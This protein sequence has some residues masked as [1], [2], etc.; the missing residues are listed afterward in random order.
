MF[1]ETSALFAYASESIGQLLAVQ[2]F[3]L[4]RLLYGHK[5]DPE[6]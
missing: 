2:L 6:P 3:R 1:L 4:L 5:T